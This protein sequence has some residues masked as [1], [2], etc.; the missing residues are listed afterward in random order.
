MNSQTK[1]NQAIMKLTDIT[2]KTDLTDIYRTFHPNK[3]KIS[4]FQHLELSPK[5]TTYSD[6]KQVSTDSRKLIYLCAS[7]KFT[8]D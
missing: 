3:T 2:K 7:Y 4:S 6:T 5:L 1:L 8:T